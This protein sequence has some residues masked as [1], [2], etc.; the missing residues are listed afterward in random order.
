M[1]LKYAYFALIR[2]RTFA[3]LALTILGVGVGLN[4]AMYGALRSLLL[5]PLPYRSPE[6]LIAISN[7]RGPDRS[8]LAVASGQFEEWRTRA[9]SFSG[10][11][12]AKLWISD[13]SALADLVGQ[14]PERL[15]I[16]FA[17]VNFFDVLG[18]EPALGRTFDAADLNGSGDIALIT[19]AFWRRHLGGDPA[20]IGRELIVQHGLGTGR[21]AQ[22]VTVIGV[23]PVNLKFSYPVETELWLPYTYSLI[24]NEPPTALG[25][26][27]IARLRPG[28]SIKAASDEMGRIAA[29]VGAENRAFRDIGV[30]VVSLHEAVFGQ[31]RTVLLLGMGVAFVVFLLVCV[32]ISNLM[33]AHYVSRRD[34]FVLRRVLGA[35]DR[36]LIRQALLEASLI[37]VGAATIGVLCAD[38]AVSILKSVIPSHIP[39]A[40]ELEMD[41]TIASVVFVTAILCSL[42]ASFVPIVSVVKSMGV[43][44]SAS[45]N[46]THLRWR[47]R[48]IGAQIAIA[49]PLLIAAALLGLS[50][51]NIQRAP[52]GFDPSDTIIME[53][54]LL[55][56]RYRSPESIRT[57]A[58]TV[59]ASVRG[60]PN[61]ES[62]EVTSSPPLG[63][64]DSTWVVNRPE[65][66]PGDRRQRI[67]IRRVGPDYFKT[68]LI[69]TRHGRVFT[70]DDLDGSQSV[71]VM[72]DALAK[73]WFPDGSALG[74][75]VELQRPTEIVGVVADVRHNAVG[76]DP[77][78]AVYLAYAQNPSSVVAVLIRTSRPSAV[79]PELRRAVAAIDPTQPVDRI[80]LVNDIVSNATATNRFSAYTTA[81]LGALALILVLVGLF[82][83]VSAIAEARTSEIGIRLALGA[84][85]GGLVRLVTYQLMSPVVVGGVV[86][87][88]LALWSSAYVKTHLFGIS[89]ISPYVYAA[90]LMGIMVISSAACIMPVRRAVTRA[91]I[92]A[93]RHS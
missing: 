80:E 79:V 87:V 9:S 59:L 90:I 86:G 30:A 35:A 92:D 24:R 2:R 55:S 4:A 77:E 14:S 81:S 23:L 27:V 68:L 56:P 10:M 32:N 38:F 6:E 75:L 52:L 44:S 65:G 62:A 18:V 41:I 3:V 53:T 19:D 72:S 34:E 15:R 11:A 36:R 83:V 17:T 93:L 43:V 71:A 20:A 39:R 64:T 91:P 48:I 76:R 7:T 49:L 25:L 89:H 21:S 8:A 31:T 45:I 22:R 46:A 16:G 74:Q 29:Q 33:L 40:D 58:E 50:L 51:W 28:V 67:R 26:S 85:P 88:L 57:F 5:Q 54:R 61:V 1:D 47:H 82:G 66:L 63:S 12:A 42:L 69:A 60:L 84:L 70:A 78:P 13:L 37:G 73:S